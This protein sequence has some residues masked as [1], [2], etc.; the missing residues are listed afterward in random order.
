MSRPEGQTAE[1]PEKAEKSDSAEVATTPGSGVSLRPSL[2]NR[3]S[4]SRRR[5]LAPSASGPEK[6]PETEAKPEYVQ[7]IIFN[8]PI[9][10]HIIYVFVLFNI[11]ILTK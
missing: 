7:T 9:L 1:Q 8:Y 2:L 10:N 5:P 3:L 4:S 6:R 11:D